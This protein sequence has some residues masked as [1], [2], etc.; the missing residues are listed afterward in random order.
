MAKKATTHF[1]CQNCGATY[2]RW[3]GKCDACGA[4]NTLVEETLP[5]KES[6]TFITGCIGLLPYIICII[7]D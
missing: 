6:P 5:T 2:S 4:W 7:M 1:V 3:A